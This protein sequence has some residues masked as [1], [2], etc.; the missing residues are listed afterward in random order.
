M[1]YKCTLQFSTK[2]TIYDLIYD[3]DVM[4]LILG[5]HLLEESIMTRSVMK[6]ASTPA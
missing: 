3:I 4:I 2:E 6:S 1:G 5:K